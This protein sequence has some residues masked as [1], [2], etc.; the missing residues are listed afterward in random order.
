MFLKL[1]FFPRFG[2]AA[3]CSLE[4]KAEIPTGLFCDFILSDREYVLVNFETVN[5]FGRF[6]ASILSVAWRDF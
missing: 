4:E 3:A 5:R 6:A 1:L 2:G